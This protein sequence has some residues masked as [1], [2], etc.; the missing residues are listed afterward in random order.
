MPLLAYIAG[1]PAHFTSKDHVFFPGQT[2]EKQLIVINNS[3]RTVTCDCAWSLALPQP[4]SSNSKVT[5]ETGQQARVPL[6]FALPAALK[7][8]VYKLAAKMKFE[9]GDVQEDEFTIQVIER[10]PAPK[11]R[12]KLALFD[13]KGETSA[14][15]KSL[16][17]RCDPVDAKADLLKYEVLVVGKSALTADG[18][19]PDIAHVREGLKV[20]IFEQTPAVLEKRFG[21]RIAEV[22]LRQVFKRVPDH[23]ALSG[24]ETEHL[25]DWRGEA[26]IIPPRL[27]KKPSRNYGFVYEWCGIMAPRIYRC[28]NRGNVASV[29]I[30]KP[31]HGDFLPI[32]DGGFSLQYSPLI[33]YREG[34]GLVLFCQMDVT[35]RTE[36]DPAAETLAANI[37]E[38]VSGWKPSP[39]RE[40]VYAG[41]PAGLKHL[42]SAGLAVGTCNGEGL[43]AD[44]VLIAGPGRGKPWPPTRI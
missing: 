36:S 31:A 8:G 32:V 29:L 34:K 27:E 24:L 26:T 28:G 17:V 30:E 1:S 35:G 2:F 39:R 6:N 44:Q 16:G 22:G 9:P 14:F 37:I 12:G 38:Y 42:Q 5:V 15:L 25:R 33:E 7:P 18:P 19:A 3:R 43:K 10:K 20:V 21:F 40:S 11:V 41:D 13:P 4:L 23:P